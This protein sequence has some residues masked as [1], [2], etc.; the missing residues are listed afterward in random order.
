ML[1][2]PPRGGSAG[3]ANVSL[4]PAPRAPL[5]SV[6]G[7]ERCGED[8]FAIARWAALNHCATC[9]RPLDGRRIEL[10]ATLKGQATVLPR[11]AGWPRPR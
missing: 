8:T 7:D 5:A 4:R 11:A 1:F 3:S 2:G 6:G 10:G 9:G